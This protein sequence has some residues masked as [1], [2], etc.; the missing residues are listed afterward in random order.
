MLPSIGEYLRCADCRKERWRGTSNPGPK[1]LLWTWRVPATFLKTSAT[2]RKWVEGGGRGGGVDVAD[3][4]QRC[5]FHL[6]KPAS[7]HLALTDYV[8]R[9]RRA[10]AA[11]A[12]IEEADEAEA[13]MDFASGRRIPTS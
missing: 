6:F 8:N 3:V 9:R 11:D 13:A 5:H 4:E 12:G 2:I 7:T 10:D 1:L